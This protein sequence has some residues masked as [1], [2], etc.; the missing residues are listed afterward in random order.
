MSDRDSLTQLLGTPDADAGCEG[1]LARLAEF[2]E[3][4]LEG[5]DPRGLLP[6]VAEHLRN[7]PACAEDYEGLLV[8]VRERGDG[9]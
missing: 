5:R 3:A 1:A 8:L 2:V 7:C 4:E 9:S 6:A